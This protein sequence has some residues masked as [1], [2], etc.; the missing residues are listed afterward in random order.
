MLVRRFI[1][2]RRSMEARSVD[3]RVWSVVLCD[4]GRQLKY[5][6]ATTEQVE[7]LIADRGLQ[8]TN[9]QLLSPRCMI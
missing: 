2:N 6:R 1:G 9:S 7:R 3:G 5:P 4:R 8:P